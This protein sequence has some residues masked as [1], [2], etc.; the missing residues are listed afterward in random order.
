M[1]SESDNDSAATASKVS[2]L[3][4]VLIPLLLVAAMF[5]LFKFAP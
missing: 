2:S 5:V 1:S 4:W 3:L